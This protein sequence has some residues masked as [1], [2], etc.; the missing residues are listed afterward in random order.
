MAKTREVTTIY[1]SR[2]GGKTTRSVSLQGAFKRAAWRVDSSEFTQAVI[3]DQ[4]G[5]R[6]YVIRRHKQGTSI[7]S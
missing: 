4:Y 6:A 7:T 5:N 3:Y 2:T 1:S